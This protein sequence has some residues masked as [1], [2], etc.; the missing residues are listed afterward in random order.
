MEQRDRIKKGIQ[1]HKTYVQ[2]ESG[3]NGTKRIFIAPCSK[4]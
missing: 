4:D 1:N 2:N 3:K